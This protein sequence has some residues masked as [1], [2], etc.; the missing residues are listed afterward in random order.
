MVIISFF[1]LFD[2]ASA[3]ASFLSSF[4]LGLVL[5]LG[6]FPTPQKPPGV[7]FFLRGPKR[8]ATKEKGPFR[9]YG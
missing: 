5:A 6:A 9:F 4:E 7:H 3:G 2:G 1:L 8:N